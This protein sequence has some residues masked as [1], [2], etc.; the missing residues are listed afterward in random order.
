MTLDSS[1][2]SR[3]LVLG[4]SFIDNKISG[5]LPLA[6]KLARLQQGDQIEK[7]AE[8]VLHRRGR[9]QEAVFLRA[10]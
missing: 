3:L 8:I 10:F 4:S 9:Q 5:K 1:S 6:S 7:L 2:L